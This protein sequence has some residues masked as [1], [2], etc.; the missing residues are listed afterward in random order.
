MPSDT[1]ELIDEEREVDDPWTRGDVRKLFHC[2]DK[3]YIACNPPASNMQ[4]AQNTIYT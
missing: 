4:V 1:K 3:E 2:N